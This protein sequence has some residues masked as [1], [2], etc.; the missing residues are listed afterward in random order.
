MWQRIN[1][2]SKDGAARSWIIDFGSL[3]YVYMVSTELYVYVYV[4]TLRSLL[5]N[6]RSFFCKL[7][8]APPAW[9]QWKSLLRV[10]GV[11]PYEAVSMTPFHTWLYERR[12]AQ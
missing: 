2:I 11:E 7:G 3:S 10:K 9:S 12:H 8:L 1:T 6:H 5:I 4:V